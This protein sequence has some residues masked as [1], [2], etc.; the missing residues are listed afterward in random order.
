MHMPTNDRPS[1]A[2][3]RPRRTEEDP[4]AEPTLSLRGISKVFPGVKALDG[5]D[6]ELHA[7]ECLGLLGQ[8]GAGKSTLVKIISGAQGPD[9]GTIRLRG[10]EL[11]FQSPR[12]AEAAGIFTVYQEMS[13]VPGLSVA[14]NIFMSNL[15]RSR[16]IVRW[17]Q[18]A[19]S[20]R[21][22]LH[23]I[24]F[25]FDVNRPVRS[26][27]VGQQQ[28]VEIA[29]AVHHNPKVLLLDEPTDTLARPDVD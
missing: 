21:E 12:D 19:R 25:D 4:G 26:L 27:P 10:R 3:S 9:A 15:P 2:P 7:G 13:L 8:N 16:G 23:S 29:K 1:A 17:G 18:V 20:A 14:E 24:G 11:R 5:V 22:I 28:A 6:L